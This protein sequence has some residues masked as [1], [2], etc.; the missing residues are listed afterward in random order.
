MDKNGPCFL[1]L[2]RRSIRSGISTPGEGLPAGG[3]SG[4]LDLA[5]R[6]SIIPLIVEYM[7][8]A[9]ADSPGSVSRLNKSIIDSAR[10]KVIHQAQRT[11]D[12]EL[13]LD[14]LKKAGLRPVI[15]KGIVCRELYPVPAARPS[16]DEDLLIRPEEFDAYHR[17]LTA[18]GFSTTTDPSEFGESDEVTYFSTVCRMCLEV[19]KYPFPRNQTAYAHLNGWLEGAVDRAVEL[20]CGR[21]E[22]L[23]LCPTDHL[24]YM[25]FHVYKHFLH[26]GF[27]IRQVCDIGLFSEKNID[28]IDWNRVRQV[29]REAGIYTFAAA[30]FAV[31]LRH[32][33]GETPLEDVIDAGVLSSIDEMPL[34]DDIMDSGVYGTSTMSRMHSSTITLGAA[35]KALKNRSRSGR[36]KAGL[37]KTVFPPLSYMRGSY[38]VL[39]KAPV[40]LP[41]TWIAR[42][43]RYLKEHRSTTKPKTGD[44]AGKSVKMG[45]GRV[46][47]MKLYGIL[48]DLND[49]KA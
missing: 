10:M 43:F 32:L 9:D 15:M 42:M 46:E 21:I 25:L 22:L 44:S 38:P 2:L 31:A 27:G 4:L 5:C 29:C 16:V 40:L 3:L 17:E 48:E 34:L 45:R 14:H 18:Y 24:V 13:L 36:A 49:G 28:L 12:L 39:K 26:G 1:N 11:A 20:R 19:H 37:L 41:F 33:L 6:H 47:L 8:E 30:V 23:T 7:L 35:E